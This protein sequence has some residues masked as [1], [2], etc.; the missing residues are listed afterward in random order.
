MSRKI[1]GLDIRSSSATAVLMESSFKNCAITGFGH[2]PFNGEGNYH[3]RLAETLAAI[4]GEMDLKDCVCAVSIP[5]DRF[6][7]HNLQVPFSEAKKIQQMLP[8]ELESVIPFPVEDLLIDFNKIPAQGSEGET[9]IIAAGIETDRMR[10]LLE[11]VESSGITPNVIHPAGYSM[12]AWLCSKSGTGTRLFVDF[13]DEDCTLYLLLEGMI[14]L[15]RSFH[16]PPA[17]AKSA[18]HLWGHIQRS[19]AGFESL[20]ET[21]VSPASI[22]VNGFHDEKFAKQLET[23]SAVSVNLLQVELPANCKF[24]DGDPGSFSPIAGFNSALS[25]A[26]YLHEGFRGM[27][28]RKGPLAAKNRLT[29]YRE[30]LTRTAIIAGVVVVL[31]LVGTVAGIFI[32]QHKVDRLQTQIAEIFKAHF[33]NNPN[34]DYPV[35]QMRTQIETLKKAAY[36]T[37]DTASQVRAIDLL[38][39]I[40]RNIPSDLDVIFTKLQLSDDGIYIDGTTASFNQVEDVKTKIQSIE[41]IDS[42][43][44]QSTARDGNRI[45]FKLRIET[46]REEVP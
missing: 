1:L 19:V 42:V 13:D 14:S 18:I 36:G 9:R 17:Q 35:V 24:S 41:D 28:F 30:R 11:A 21:R 46:A 15:I 8:Y 3:E 16:L 10:I 26:L 31:W 34:T 5:S 27:N 12:A 38:R 43:E 20:F 44:P 4:S 29:E 37:T 25:C 6:F 39:S 22:I 33:P 7:Y 32:T 45:R 23:V 2:A 40:S